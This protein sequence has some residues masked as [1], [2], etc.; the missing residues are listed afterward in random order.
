ML[1]EIKLRLTPEQAASPE[2]VRGH[3]LRA[4][5]ANSGNLNDWRVVRRSIDSRQ[6]RI[7]VELS[8]RVALGED[9]LL[10]PRFALPEY[11]D[12]NSSSPSLIIV[13]AGPAGLFAALRCLERG[14][15]PILI[16][17]GLSVDERR[18]VLADISRKGIVDVD[19][20]YCFGEGG[21]G[22]Y[23]D[24]KLFTR[25][26]KRGNVGA[27]LQALHLHGAPDAILT[28][29]HPHIGS[30]KLPG[31]IRNI[32][33]TIIRHG[34]EVHFST[35]VT[36]LLMRNGRV[37]GVNTNKGEYMADAVVLA[38]GHSARD[39]YDILHTRGVP[40]EVKGIAMGVRLEHPQ[41]LIDRLRYHCSGDR[42]EYLPPAEYSYVAQSSGRGVY[43]FCMC[44]GG[45]IVPAASAPE[46]L[47]V[48]GMSASGRSGRLANS[49]IVV[50]IRPGDFP[51][52]DKYGVFAHLRLQEDLEKKFYLDG[53]PG[54]NAPAQRMTDFVA[55]HD[56][57]GDLQRTTYAPGIHNG[58]L[59][60]LLPPFIADRLAEGF[61]AFN[62]KN[63]GFMTGE[64]LMV[65]LESRTS[66]PIRVPRD[67]ESRC[68]PEVPGLYPVGEG[69]G[70]AGGIVSAGMDGMLSADA[71]ADAMSAKSPARD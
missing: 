29:A 52:Y 71:F 40:M 42:G 8:V 24:G 62:R 63:Q 55:C 43:S 16:E 38:T 70:Y 65:G 67:K 20:N 60:K 69:A 37:V 18:L 14:V 19:T 47:V 34:G 22:A 5:P 25:S 53:E 12:V 56:S 4:L 50:E 58:R 30:D 32:R 39:I 9:N 10:V 27:V 26:K 6:K 46:E 7:V 21:A 17:R 41:P 45:V 15:R 44:P 11:K 49:G 61:R 64:G 2:E 48:N 51:E 35:R 33:Q 68:H 57:R 54:L 3:I 13:G 59:D 31:V 28:D 23:S 1:T 36:D 66:S